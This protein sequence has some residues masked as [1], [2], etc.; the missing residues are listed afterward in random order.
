MHAHALQ[1]RHEH[2]QRCVAG[3][4]AEPGHRA[5][6]TRRTGLDGGQGVGNRHA[7]VVVAMEADLG[8][9]L[10]PLAQR[11]D[12]LAH[13]IRQHVARRV[14]A[15]D[16]VGAVALHQARL[17]QQFLGAD[18]VRHHQEAH[19]IQAHLAG[20]ADMLAGHIG[21]GAVGG[22]AKGRHPMLMGH[23]QVVEGADARQQQRRHLGLLELGD[24]R[25]EIG[26]VAVSGH[27]VVERGPAQAIA[28]GDLDQRHAGGVQP[29][30]HRHH[31]LQADL[32]AL[33]MHAIAQA[34]V[35]QQHVPTLQVHRRAPQRAGSCRVP[36]W[37]CS[38][39]ISAVRR[40]AAV[41]M[42]RLPA[43]LGR[44][45]PS[46]CTSMKIDTLLPSNTGPLTRV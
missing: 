31:L 45:S 4:G 17:L 11:A 9:R 16:A 2:L 14:G 44:K 25:A 39:N 40:P 8:I 19:G 12:F 36:L 33:G 24:Y 27:A 20:H 10:Q 5:V 42:S 29:G 35:V 1:H 41:M 22:H 46:P 30:G 37:A 6:D 7:Q 3:P 23:L 21:L 28:M 13:L 15:I 43:D 38:A 34:H 32:V 26:L 18:P